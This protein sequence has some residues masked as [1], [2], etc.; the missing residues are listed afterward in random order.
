MEEISKIISFHSLC[1]ENLKLQ[2]SEGEAK[3][4]LSYL[5]QLK[6]DIV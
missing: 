3:A 5:K 1:L 2:I 6:G 4:L